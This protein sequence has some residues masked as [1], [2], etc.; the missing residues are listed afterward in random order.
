MI[1]TK[2]KGRKQSFLIIGNRGGLFFILL[3]TYIFYH[4]CYMKFKLLSVEAALLC[5]GI[6]P[7]AGRR[8]VSRIHRSQ[9]GRYRCCAHRYT[10]VAALRAAY[11]VGTHKNKQDSAFP[12]SPVVKWRDGIPA[13]LYDYLMMISVPLI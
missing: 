9:S 13:I 8:R 4:I 2:Y 11:N 3:F 10:V 5:L 6:V 7:L 12:R 1:V